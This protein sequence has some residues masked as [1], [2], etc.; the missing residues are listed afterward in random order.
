MKE[1]LQEFVDNWKLINSKADLHTTLT[2]FIDIWHVVF[3]VWPVEQAIVYKIDLQLLGNFI[4]DFK[5]LLEVVRAER[6]FGNNVKIWEV[7]GLGCDEVRVC[8]VFKWFL[9]CHAEHGQGDSL[10]SE[11]VKSLPNKPTQFPTAETIQVKPYWISVE[12]CASGDRASRIDIEIEGEEFLLFF[13]VKIYAGETN[14]QLKRY[15]KIA[16]MKAGNRPWGIIFL[17]PKGITTSICH[18]QLLKISWKDVA[19]VFQNHVRKNIK[20][21]SSSSNSLSNLLIS[22]FSQYIT[23]F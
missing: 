20:V 2:N 7:A 9:D 23:R 6:R 13:E 5:P 18:P 17:A 16:D 4:T 22:Q 19:N 10:L 15:L 14:D 3:K 1:K 12:T 21:D 11:I 8:S